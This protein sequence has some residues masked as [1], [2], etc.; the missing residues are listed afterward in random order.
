MP[1]FKNL[2]EYHA[3]LFFAYQAMTMRAVLA[4]SLVGLKAA[5]LAL[6]LVCFE[7]IAQWGVWLNAVYIGIYALSALVVYRFVFRNENQ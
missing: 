5:A 7:S 6:L 3:E 2:L 4:T 1:A